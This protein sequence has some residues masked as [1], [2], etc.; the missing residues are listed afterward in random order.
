MNFKN[1]PFIIKYFIIFIFV[2]LVGCTD[3]V[4]ES[5]IK[6]ITDEYKEVLRSEYSLNG[7]TDEVDFPDEY[8]GASISYISS[9]TLA[10]TQDGKVHQSDAI[11][12]VSLQV[13][14]E[15]EGEESS[16]TI[17]VAILKKDNVIIPT[18]EDPTSEPT[19][20]DVPTEVPGEY[21]IEL[22]EIYLSCNNLYGD[23]L[24]KELRI[25]TTNMHTKKTTYGNLRDQLQ[26]TDVDPNNP[27]NIILFY[28][29]KSVKKTWDG[30]ST[31]NREHVWPRSTGW[32]QE[33]GAGCDIHHIRPTD[34]GVNSARGNDKFADV[35]SKGYYVP[36]DEVKGDI[37]RI[38]FYL[39]VRYKES[40]NKKF[41]DVAYSLEMLLEWNEL[42]PVSSN[43][44]YRNNEGQK[45]QG[46]YNPFIIHPEFADLIW[47]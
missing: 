2:L 15:L 47:A 8:K 45:I 34:P 35:D 7:L 36:N 29:Q 32:F 20:P 17:Q 21:P 33:D 39:M 44:I 27:N 42:D 26:K 13:K 24:F 14:I 25:I 19:E 10:V 4:D 30:G 37:A 28:T 31:W 46:N 43:E 41:T 6:E 12:L 18:P 38:I 3:V 9:D 11:K 23:E 22:N 5:N 1:K 40:D 16:F